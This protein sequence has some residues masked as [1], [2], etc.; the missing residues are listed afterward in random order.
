MKKFQAHPGFSVSEEWFFGHVARQ[1]GCRIQMCT[2]V[3]V[4]TE[5]PNSIFNLSFRRPRQM[6]FRGVGQILLS[7]QPPLMGFRMTIWKQRF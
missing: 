5:T 3:F 7:L 6:W 4:E 2:A 1:L